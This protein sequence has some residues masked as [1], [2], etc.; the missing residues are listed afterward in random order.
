MENQHWKFHPREWIAGAIVWFLLLM[1]K[2][3]VENRIEEM[4]LDPF[5]MF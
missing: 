4:N 3:E 2:L 1:V 5:G